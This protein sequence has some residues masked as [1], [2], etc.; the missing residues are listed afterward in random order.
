MSKTVMDREPH[1]YREQ[2]E[3][4]PSLARLFLVTLSPLEEMF[5]SVCRVWDTRKL[6]SAQMEPFAD[7]KTYFPWKTMA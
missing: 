1:I 6:T 5:W 3:V 4:H 2:P 7:L